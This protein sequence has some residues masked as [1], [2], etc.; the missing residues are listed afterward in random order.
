MKA[1]LY[2]KFPEDQDSFDIASKSLE[3]KQALSQFTIWLA[4]MKTEE[5]LDKKSL[6]VIYAEFQGLL[7]DHGIELD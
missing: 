4:K 6:Q 1:I 5:K 7:D 3:L 2:F